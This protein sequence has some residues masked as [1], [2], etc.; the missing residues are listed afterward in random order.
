MTECEKKLFDLC[1]EWFLSV[2]TDYVEDGETV[3]R[4]NENL[5][6]IMTAME[7]AF[8]IPLLDSDFADFRGNYPVIAAL[9]CE[10]SDARDFS[11]YPGAEEDT[12]QLDAKEE[13]SELSV[14]VAFNYVTDNMPREIRI[15]VFTKKQ[16]ITVVSDLMTAHADLTYFIYYFGSIDSLP[17]D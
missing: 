13:D 9:Y 10:I 16:L 2:R 1:Y 7:R 15:T 14:L 4:Y 5:G 6:R 11:I 3:Q 17:N 8:D 12:F